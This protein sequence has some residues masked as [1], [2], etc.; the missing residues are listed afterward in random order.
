M[1]K[2][3]S[4]SNSGSESVSE[5]EWCGPRQ[6]EIENGSK[7]DET[8]QETKQKEPVKQVH[9]H[10]HIVKDEEDQVSAA[11]RRK[12]TGFVSLC[13]FRLFFTVDFF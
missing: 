7:E 6:D 11:K 4:D 3:E 5:E 12:R 1:S 8:S 10:D 13:L 9:A 2:I